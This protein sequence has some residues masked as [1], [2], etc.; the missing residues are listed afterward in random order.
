MRAAAR[1]PRA[2]TTKVALPLS[3]ELRYE[4]MA[5]VHVLTIAYPGERPNAFRLD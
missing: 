5:H 2:S 4:V 1:T 3:G